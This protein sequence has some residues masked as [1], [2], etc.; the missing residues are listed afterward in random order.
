MILSEAYN[1][2]CVK[3]MK[4]LPDKHF[5]IAIC[6][7]EYRDVNQP[8]IHMRKKG[9]LKTWKGAPK[10]PYFKEL[11]RVSENQVIFGG[12]YF[13]DLIN[14][15]TS[16]PFLEANNNWYIWDKKV[17][18]G[19]HFS[20]AEMAW[21]SK[22]INVRVFRHRPIGEVADWHETAKPISVYTDL[23]SLYC[24]K[25][26]NILDT[27]LGSGS[28]RIAAWALGFDFIGCEIDEKYFRLSCEDFDRYKQS[29]GLFLSTVS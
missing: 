21:V 19:L 13:T 10:A 25:G 20:Q 5:S 12:N 1:I 7:P 6:D 18:R 16:L 8:D 15:E 22:R 2:D 11:F 17:A 28:S 24:E 4:T 9:A 23:F 14:P 26:D 29:N 27:N 3:Y